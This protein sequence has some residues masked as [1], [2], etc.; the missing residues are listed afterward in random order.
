MICRKGFIISKSDLSEEK[1][2]WLKNELT[3]SPESQSSSFSCSDESF[4]VF[5]ESKSRFRIP[6]HFGIHNFGPS[7]INKLPLGLSI[8]VDFV[9]ILKQSTNQQEAV[10]SSLYN[11]NTYGGGLLSLPTGYGKTCVALY[12]LSKLKVKTLI[13]VHKTFLMN[14]WIE[15]IQQFLPSATIGKIQKDT[16]DIDGKDIVI[17]MLQ[18]L[19]M[20]SYE[21][22]IF[23]S[24]GF[25]IID[26]THHISSK[27]FSRALF[28][29]CTKYTLGLSATPYRKDGLTKVLNWFI[30]DIFYSV[31][32]SNDCTVNVHIHSF[33]HPSFLLDPP[34]NKLGTISL[35]SVINQLVLIPERNTFIISS[36][37]SFLKQQRKIIVLSDRRSHCELLLTSLVELSIN[38]GLYMGGMKQS[39]L[40]SNEDCD[41]LLATYSLAQEGLDIPSLDT[42]ILATPKTDVVQSC[43]RILRETSGKKNSPLILDISDKFA[44][45]PNQSRK[46]CKFYKSSGF[47]IHYDSISQPSVN[48]YSFVDD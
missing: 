25:T 24:F 47:S 18:S 29:V 40:K 14:Q 11:I 23:D 21:P 1:I 17:G 19:S 35:P 43:G 16:I 6:R 20:K 13:I 41:V 12:I 3:V 15:R 37:V 7:F 10:D 42:L 48:S 31:S 38:A 44:S 33:S 8:N 36:L 34:L 5:R 28:N 4:P 27:V 32:R 39:V 46:R 9:G 26:E 2:K 30:G 45:L 22:H